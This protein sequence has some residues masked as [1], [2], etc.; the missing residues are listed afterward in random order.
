MAW[1]SYFMGY[2]AI[3][4]KMRRLVGLEHLSAFHHCGAAMVAGAMTMTITNPIWVVKTRMCLQNQVRAP[5]TVPAK[6]VDSPWLA[7]VNP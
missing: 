2:D 5:D 1:G 6:H 7:V 4:G 3:K